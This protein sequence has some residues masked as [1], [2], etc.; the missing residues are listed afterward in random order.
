MPSV[1]VNSKPITVGI[2]LASIKRNVTSACA[3]AHRDI[4]MLLKSKKS[5]ADWNSFFICKVDDL[6]AFYI[7]LL[8][9]GLM[10]P[11]V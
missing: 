8:V 3:T 11:L 10:R 2:G 7:R 5:N 6:S 1:E 9:T 4:N